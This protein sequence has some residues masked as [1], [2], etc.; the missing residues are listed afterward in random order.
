M[1]KGRGVCIRLH[2]ESWFVR[3]NGRWLYVDGTRL[4]KLSAVSAELNEK[5]SKRFTP[6]APLRERTASCS[7]GY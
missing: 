7:Q 3:Y 4:T 6:I 5:G 2:D 1:D